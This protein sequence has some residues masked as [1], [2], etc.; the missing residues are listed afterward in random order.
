MNFLYVECACCVSADSGTN[1]THAR[2]K[3]LT[4]RGAALAAVLQEHRITWDD[5]TRG[6]YR[7]VRRENE[8]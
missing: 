7:A 1:V 8:S 6:A 4:N 3:T 5:E 2:E